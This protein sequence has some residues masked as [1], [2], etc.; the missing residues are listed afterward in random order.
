MQGRQ[1]TESHSGI[2]QHP[3]QNGPGRYFSKH[4]KTHFK[5]LYKIQY[6]R[7]GR[8]SQLSPKTHCITRNNCT[9]AEKQTC[10]TDSLSQSII[11]G[12][13]HSCKVYEQLANSLNDQLSD[14][15]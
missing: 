12:H 9:L 8:Q 3:Y 1:H 4:S 7:H 2:V 15:S 5:K 14:T 10:C 11:S 13:K 6:I